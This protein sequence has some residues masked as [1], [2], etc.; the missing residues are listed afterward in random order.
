MPVS[1]AQQ[2]AVNKYNTKAYDRFSLMLPK[3]RKAEIEAFAKEKGQSVNGWINQLIRR[4]MGISED[5]W[6][7]DREETE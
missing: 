3:G 4:E 1:K 6:K 5:N 7:R 2:K